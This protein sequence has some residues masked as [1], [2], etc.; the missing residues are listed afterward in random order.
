MPW[1]SVIVGN[2]AYVTN[3]LSSTISVLNISS[4]ASANVIETIAIGNNPMGIAE[5]GGYIYTVLNGLGAVTVL[6]TNDP[7]YA[8]DIPPILQQ[9][10]R[11]VTGT[12]DAAQPPG[13]NWSGVASGGWTESWAQWVNGGGG[14]A[15]C[16]RML[17]YSTAQGRWIIG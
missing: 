1:Q 13:L 7:T 10:G 16:T 9:F 12:C 14:G 5:S 6:D 4:P 3:Y 11:P 15:V 17:V 2:Y 8:A